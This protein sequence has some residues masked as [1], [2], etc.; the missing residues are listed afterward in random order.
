[1]WSAG[2]RDGGQLKGLPLVKG[3]RVEALP[4]YCLHDLATANFGTKTRKAA[5][6]KWFSYEFSYFY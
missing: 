5:C 1:M 2:M 6:R 4:K 3:L